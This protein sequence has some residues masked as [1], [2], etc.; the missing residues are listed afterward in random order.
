MNVEADKKILVVDDSEDMRQ[1]LQQILEEEEI[2][3]LYF[4]E[5]GSEAIERAQK[6]HPDL[7][8]MDMSLP[9]MTGWE[10]V[11]YL[12][13]L[14]AFKQTPI[15]AVTAHVSQVDQD[16]AYAIGCTSHLGKPFDVTQV[17]DIVAD[18]LH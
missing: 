16:R 17:L 13:Q 4:A 2:Y 1:L 5:D 14:P 10:A 7:I 12:R 18:N 15:I 6:V 9:G 3:T 8:L 11:A